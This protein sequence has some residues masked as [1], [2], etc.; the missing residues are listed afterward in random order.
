MDEATKFKNDIL[1]AA[2]AHLESSAKDLHLEDLGIKIELID[3]SIQKE[4]VTIEDNEIKDRLVPITRDD[5]EPDEP[6]IIEPIINISGWIV[7]APIIL[8][9]NEDSVIRLEDSKAEETTITEDEATNF[10]ERGPKIQQILEEL[11][12]RL[13]VTALIFGLRYV[14]DLLT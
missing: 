14:L 6:L 12:V 2:K 4:S 10:K 9:I 3:V 5:I 1:S 11:I 7:N 8:N 13:V